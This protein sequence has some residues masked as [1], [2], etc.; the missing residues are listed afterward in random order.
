MLKAINEKLA[1]VEFLLIGIDLLAMT[2]LA[3]LQVLSRYVFKTSYPWLEEGVRFL[4]FWLTYLGV[5]LLIYKSNNVVIDFVPDL[6][7]EKAGFDITPVLDLAV[8]CFTVYFLVQTA[9][10]L[11]STVFYA[12]KSQ[13]MSLPMVAVYSVFA[14]G[15]GL[16]I[17]HACSN[18]VF[19]FQKWRKDP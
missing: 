6:V 16:A 17:F 14:I 11:Q 13:V 12:Q 5:P 15:N 1:Q 18:F 19:R 9:T 2:A 10:F 4:M 7:R 8:L 3:F